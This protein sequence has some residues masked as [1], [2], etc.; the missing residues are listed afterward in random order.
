[1]ETGSVA[2]FSVATFNIRG[3]MDRWRERRPVLQRCLQE[4][5]S[6]VLCFQECLTG[7]YGQDRD[8]LGPSYHVFPCKAALFNLL[9]PGSG[10]LHQAYARAVGAA[11]AVGPCRRLM[12]SLPVAV[13]AFRERFK[14]EGTFF[15]TLR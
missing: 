12:A 11:L 2:Q 4:L 14:L 3:I 5:D 8:L 10:A 7:E 6:D 1:M 9:S 15:R 13:E